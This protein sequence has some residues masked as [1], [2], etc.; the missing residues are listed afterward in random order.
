MAHRLLFGFERTLEED[1]MRLGWAIASS[2]VLALAGCGET[3][4]DEMAGTDQTP[5]EAEQPAAAPEPAPGAAAPDVAAPSET[6]PADTDA[7]L[8]ITRKIREK[9]VAEEEP[10]S[11]Q[12]QNVAVTAEN[13]VVTL[14]GRVD[15][16]QEKDR[17]LE[18]VRATE[19]VTNVEDQIEVAAP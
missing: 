8:E 10:L 12:A 3:R 15:S 16:Q 5:S 7:D 14:S 9:L 2:L 17:V 18:I 19:G 11:D 6:P 13:G 4:D 1:D